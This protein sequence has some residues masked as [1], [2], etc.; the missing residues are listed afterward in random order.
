MVTQELRRLVADAIGRA[1]AAGAIPAPPE[2]LPPFEVEPPR[3]PK[4]GDYAANAALMLARMLGRPPR[5]IA[6]AIK[7]HLPAPSDDLRAVEIAGPGFL[8]L[9]L[10]P[11]FLHR[12]L[13]RAHAEDRRFGRTDVGRGRRVLV[14]YVSANPTGPLH[15]GTGRNGA[16]GET[17]ARLLDALGYA[18]AREYYVNDYGTQVDT[19]ARSV[20]ARYLELL[21][22]PAEFPE[23][24]YRGDYVRDIAGR[25]VDEHGAGL[26]DVPSAERLPLIRDT[27]LRLLLGQIRTTLEEF[28][29]TFDTWFSERTLH[30]SGAVERCLAELRRRGVVYEQDGA[31]WF[32]STQFGDDKDRVIV[33]SDGR[34]TYF[35]AD[36]P[37]HMDKYARGYEH[38][39]DVWGVDHVGDTARVRGG[40]QALGHD[41][42]TM[43][44]I[45]YQHVR[46]RNEGEAVRMSKRSGEFITLGELIQ[47]VGRDAARFFFILTSPSAPMDFDFALAT[48]QSAENPVYYVQ[49]AHARIS[50]ILREAER[51]GVPLPDARRTDLLPLSTPEEWSLAK[52][53]AA[54]PDVVF[55]AGTRR[56]PQ[57]LCA[58]ARELAE[59]FHVF[60]GQCRVLTDDA[61]LTAARLVLVG[62]SQRALRNTL[63]LAGVTAV[64]RMERP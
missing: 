33:R 9:H 45:L 26:A 20:E 24:G 11:A 5:E 51:Q 47:A 29:I 62:A 41:P 25:I 54:M 63:D 52:R 2:P 1:A 37:Y 13:R 23:D 27:A 56:E 18:V 21:N 35:A 6:A 16:V 31:L 34:P 59:A 17:I 58:Y 4:H 8:N 39:I 15:V 42:E 60:Y 44:F 57:R 28:G 40:L 48:R 30:E 7:A 49:Y 46:L 12:W 55:A 10:A 3:D 50:S 14:E 61:A 64:E 19:L 43:E 38:L 22:R 32:R 36:V 53:I